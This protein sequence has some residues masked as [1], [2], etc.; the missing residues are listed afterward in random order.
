MRKHN[1]GLLLGLI[2]LLLFS[3]GCIHRF[4]GSQV[5]MDFTALQLSAAGEHYE[6]M[7]TINDSVVSV[8]KFKAQNGK[9]KSGGTE[10]QIV[11]FFTGEKYGV[12]S[13]TGENLI[14]NTGAE[15]SIPKN[16]KNAT[17]VFLVIKRD[18]DPDVGVGSRVLLF[19]KAYR[20]YGVVRAHLRPLSAQDVNT[21]AIASI[22]FI[23]AED[24]TFF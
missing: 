24:T 11:D 20:E 6:V 9:T 22:T 10:P 21:K 15:F 23:I 5:V 17:E 2:G 19:G 14:T 13:H 3:Q 8:I 12:V 7:A 4:H 1:I 16:L 18:N